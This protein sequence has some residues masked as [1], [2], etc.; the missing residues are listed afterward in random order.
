MIQ[1]S[2]HSVIPGLPAG[3]LHSIF[4]YS[5]TVEHRRAFVFDAVAA[6]NALKSSWQNLPP[7]WIGPDPCGSSW[8]GIT[9]TNSHVTSIVL[10]GMGVIGSMSGDILSFS[11]LQYL[12]LSNNKDLTGTL[13]PSIGNLKNL[14]S[15]I[16]VGCSFFGPI[17]DSIGSL[18]QLVFL[19]L[20]SNSFSGS[21]PPSIGN[22]SNLEWLDISNNKLNG[23]IPVSDGTIPGLDM[24]VS[25]KHFHF[26][27]N[28]LYGAIPPQL[29]SSNMVLIHVIFDNNQFTG[30]IPFSLGLVQTLEVVRLDWNSFS[31][32]VPSNFN[33][34]TSVNELYLSNN[35]LT[36]PIPNLTGMNFLDY[37]DMSNNSFNVSDVPPW[38]SRL[39]SLTTLLMEHTQLQG[40][41]PVNLFSLPHLQNVVLSNNHLN[42][43]LNIGTSYNNQ[44]MLDL[45]NNSIANFAQSAGYNIELTLMENPIC[46]GAGA[47]ERYCS[48]SQPSNSSFLTPSN[49]CTSVVCS[50]DKVSSPNCKCAYPYIGTLNF[51]SFS[52]SNL[53]NSSYFIFL[54]GS[55][56]SVFLS[57]L[58]PV[59]SVSVSNPTINIY[60]Y[61]QVRLQVFPSGQDYF[62]RTEISTIGTLLNR[63][64]FQPLSYFG[65]F[66]FIDENY[67]CFAGPNKSSN[68][69]II[70]GAVVGSFV[71]VLLLVCAGIYAFH[72]KRIVKTATEQNPFASWS[73]DKSNGNAPQLKGARSFSFE[74]IK[75]CTNNFSEANGIGFGG[76]GKVYRGTLATGLVVAIKRAQQGSLQGALEFKTEIELLSRIHHKNVVSLV[77]FCYEKGEQ[78]LVY[79]YIPNGTIRESLSGKSG[80]RLN[81][82]RRLR[83]ALDS[84]RGLAY[85]HELANPPIIHRDIKSNNILLDEHLDAK[86]ADFGLSKLMGDSEKGYVTTQVKGT[87]GYMDPEYYMTQQLTEKSDVYSFGVVLLELITARAPIEKGRHIV[88]E[89]EEVISKSKDPHNL[90][91]I[92]D[93]TIGLGATL[94]GLEQF[95]NLAMSCVKE[96]G[97]DRPTMGEVV[98]KIENIMQLASLNENTES[99][100]ASSSNEEEAERNSNH[101][102]G[103]EA[104]DY[105]GGFI[106]FDIQHY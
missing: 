79:E 3:Y 6:L 29:F 5:S 43:T 77:G 2:N 27:N 103:N 32:S 85:L 78:M 40:Q 93:P 7:N 74:E 49:N 20:N 97:P 82:M 14:S 66:Y 26:A 101:P 47:S 92:L 41:I 96:S 39:Q 58:L 44:L 88:R 53:T 102:Y 70:V 16:L 64:S 63:Q 22:L 99:T 81:W 73:P 90:H 15:L 106:P 71:L 33:N 17:P 86:V 94:G 42:G 9:C 76:Y 30:N 61:L 46:E 13:P 25:T 38:V 100:F 21:I 80:I 75:K 67:C 55:L 37:V 60:S 12:D 59:D 18:Q 10:A 72:Q 19:S 50:S 56:M 69:G 4:G 8:E 51:R 89:M 54:E 98:R 35:N 68:I 57:N 48:V 91:G 23:T 104:F 28:L 65:P 87:L 24:L 11:G 84:A 105:S 36:G 95:V 83:I 62:N 1:G 52:F 45:Q 34:L 31:G